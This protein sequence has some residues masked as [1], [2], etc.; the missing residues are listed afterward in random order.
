MNNRGKSINVYLMDGTVNGVIKCTLANWTGVSYKI[1]R[2]EL[3]KHKNREH[4]LQSGVYFLFGTDENSGDDVVYIGQAGLRKSGIGLYA[5]LQE[6]KSNSEKDY[7][8][9]AIVFTTSNNSFGPTEISWLENRFCAI[10]KDCKRYII[11]NSNEPNIGN[12][13]EE[14]ECELEEFV[15]YAKIIM[16]T[17]GHKVFEKLNSGTIIEHAVNLNEAQHE[18][19]EFILEIKQNDIDSKGK[20]TSDG[21]ILLS[22]SK[23][24]TEVQSSCPNPAKVMREKYS[25]NINSQGI[26]S[27]D[28]LFKSPNI[29][30]SFVTG[31]STNARKEWKTSAGKTL[32][33]LES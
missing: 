17:L 22:N 19:S 12:V 11:K 30:A 7:W 15:D 14:K 6:H 33:D 24:R 26:I 32:N 27:E 8:S 28:I 10:A 18:H 5:R 3:E 25:N 20:L 23:I 31:R 16:G 9:E 13:T 4:L 29:A 21:F 1:P 2:T